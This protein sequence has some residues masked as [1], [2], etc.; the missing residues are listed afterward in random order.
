[1]K[2]SEKRM[3]EVGKVKSLYEKWYK[4]VFSVKTPDTEIAKAKRDGIK[5]CWLELHK[6]VDN[7][8]EIEVPVEKMQNLRLFNHYVEDTKDSLVEL[9]SQLK[10]VGDLLTKTERERFMERLTKCAEAMEDIEYEFGEKF[11]RKTY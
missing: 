11:E 7:N 5:E 2:M 8:V 6:V 4:E 1:M 3:M 9:V 10:E